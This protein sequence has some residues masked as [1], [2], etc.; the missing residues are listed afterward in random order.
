MLKKLG[1]VPKE[2]KQ[3]AR[4][5]AELK[6][7]LRQ[8]KSHRCPKQ[9]DPKAVERE[10]AQAVATKEREFN[11]ERGE[12]QKQMT[13]MFS[14]LEQIGRAVAKAVKPEKTTIQY[15]PIVIPKAIIEPRQSMQ[16]NVI[17]DEDSDQSLTGGALR[18]LQVLVSRYPMK[19]TKPQLATFSKLS[20]RSGTFGTYF[21]K[22]KSFAYIVVEG[23]LISASEEGIEYI[24]EAP[25]PPQT[26]EEV[27]EMW[28]NNLKGGA[29]RMFDVLVENYPEFMDKELVGTLTDLSSNSG[30]FGTY[31]SMLK[32]NGLVEVT[33]GDIKASDNLFLTMG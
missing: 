9:T 19:L 18:M 15:P 4:T 31:L 5:I 23:K 1:D 10:V 22:L 8:A 7:E 13:N 14:I 3:E 29:R 16:A 32:S 26:S 17:T 20:P 11:R 21:S 24:G 27:I 30:T 6:T 2:A 28:R 25:N 33:N 12:W